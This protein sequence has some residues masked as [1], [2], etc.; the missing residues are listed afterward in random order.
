MKVEVGYGDVVDRVSILLRKEARMADPHKLSHVRA[1]LAALRD[2]W[3]TEGLPPIES[4]PSW[5][6]LCEV[7]AALWD[8]EDALREDER[9][10]DFGD[11][12]VARARSVYAL[13]DERARLKA[14]INASLGSRIV[15]VK[16][17]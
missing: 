13:N 7:N 3:S 16:S 17:Y 15:E 9:R 12:F 2:A 8:V 5:V 11:G 4:L 14:Q 10:S 1:E 6:R